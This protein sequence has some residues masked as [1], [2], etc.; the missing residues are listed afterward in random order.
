MPP[1]KDTLRRYLRSVRPIFDDETYNRIKKESEDFEKGI[2]KKLQ[3]YL[4]LKSW[5]ANNYVS[6]WWEEYIYLKS[7][8]PIMVYSNVFSSDH[9][10]RDTTIQSA[11]AANMSHLLFKFRESI[12]NQT[13]PPIM[14]QNMVPLCS[15][16]YE[17]LFNTTRIPGVDGDKI[18][19]FE[20]SNHFAVLHKGCYYKVTAVQNGRILKPREI[21][22][23]LD[24]I[25]DSNPTSSHGEKHLASLT[26]WNRTKWA[27][28]RDE[29]F[30]NGINKHSLNAIESAAFVLHLYEEPY[31]M[32]LENL[33]NLE[34]L[35]HF[36]KQNFFGRV[37]DIWFDKSFNIGFGTNG[38][39]SCLN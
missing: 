1:L 38:V 24:F 19:H 23:Q 31:V 37:Y 6:D 17:R 26:A 16:Q 32:D 14:A 18:V 27:E 15:T 28:T 10:S 21:Q 12:E 2:G 20:E 13:L 9:V 35:H 39:V 25:I 5:W 22:H 29:F 11:R 33:D 4:V 30:A 3:R 36:G 8:S 7:S 34:S